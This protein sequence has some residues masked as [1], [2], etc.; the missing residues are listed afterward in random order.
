MS[1]LTQPELNSIREIASSHITNSAKLKAY[2]NNCKDAKLKQMFNTS[3][4]Q[5][6]Q[7]ATKL[8]QML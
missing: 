6:E 1:K 2:G 3:A 7:T 4:A 5:A 8:M